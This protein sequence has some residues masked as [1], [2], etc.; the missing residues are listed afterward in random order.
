MAWQN[1]EQKRNVIDKMKSQSL[2][3]QRKVFALEHQNIYNS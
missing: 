2:N 1:A 3:R